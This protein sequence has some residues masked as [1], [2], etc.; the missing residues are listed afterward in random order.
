MMHPNNT[1]FQIE[2]LFDGDLEFVH[3]FIYTLERLK[4][5]HSESI[6]IR[7]EMLHRRSMNIGER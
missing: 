4:L 7:I 6:L 3:N 2:D 5:A 1:T